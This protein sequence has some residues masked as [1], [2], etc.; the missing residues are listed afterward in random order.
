MK[1]KPTKEISEI[2]RKDPANWKWGIFYYNKLDQRL[3][4]PKRIPAMGYTINFANKKSLLFF[5]LLTLIPLAIVGVF[6]FI[7]HIK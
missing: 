1:L 3:M 7:S 4:P 2:W 6:V 5:L